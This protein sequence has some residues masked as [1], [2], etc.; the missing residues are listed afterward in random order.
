VFQHPIFDTHAVAAQHRIR[1]LQGQRNTWYCGA[2]L[3]HG[4]HED[5]LVSAM[6]VAEALGT[7]APWVPAGGDHLPFARK[8]ELA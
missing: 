3:R 5:G 7:P 8:S 4:F 2:Y 1:R 6:A